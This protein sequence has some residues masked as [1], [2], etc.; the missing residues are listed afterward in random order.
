MG[1]MY[2]NCGEPKLIFG[3]CAAVNALPNKVVPVLYPH[4][5]Y[6]CSS[7]MT[8]YH[9]FENA[10]QYLILYGLSQRFEVGMTSATSPL[11][12]LKV[13]SQS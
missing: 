6:L 5:N 11:R 1:P 13:W 8:Y 7:L 3:A 2:T 10:D 12:E 9:V 4:V